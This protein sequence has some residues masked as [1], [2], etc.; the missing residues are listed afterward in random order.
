MFGYDKSKY[1]FNGSHQFSYLYLDENKKEEQPKLRHSFKAHQGINDNLEDQKKSKQY[2]ISKAIAFTY[3]FVVSY[4]LALD[5]VALLT[6]FYIDWFMG[7]NFFYP[8]MK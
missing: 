7:L 5:Q 6:I 8:L 2:S 4:F 3:F 1:Q